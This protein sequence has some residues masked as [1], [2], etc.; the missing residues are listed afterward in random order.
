MMMYGLA[1]PLSLSGGQNEEILR[2]MY[3]GTVWKDEE[4]SPVSSLKYWLAF[5]VFFFP[6][7]LDIWVGGILEDQ[8]DGAKVGP[9]LRCLLV[10]Q[11]RR[12]R[13]GDRS[14]GATFTIT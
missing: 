9:T 10:E 1:N 13:D 3:I 14:V 12:L 5:Y 11:F 4:S 7:N 2:A 6:G 8:V